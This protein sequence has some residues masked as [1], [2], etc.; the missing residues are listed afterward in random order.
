VSI[1]M[2]PNTMRSEGFVEM[3]GHEVAIWSSGDRTF[4]LV[5]RVSRDEITQMASA[6]K[7]AL[8]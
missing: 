3:L 4:V 5:A 8:Q 7:G 1:Y 2:L 6:V